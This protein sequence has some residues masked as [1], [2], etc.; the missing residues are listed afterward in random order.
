MW[1]KIMEF[2]KGFA[3]FGLLFMVLLIVLL[4]VLLPENY[5]KYISQVIALVSSLTALVSIIWTQYNKSVEEYN[6]EKQFE[7]DKKH[8]IS[9]EKYQKLFEQKID[10]YQKL[11]SEINK[12]K[13]QSY[14]VGRYIDKIDEYGDIDPQELKEEDVSIETLEKLFKHIGENHFVISNKMMEKY[15]ALYDLYAESRKEFNIMYDFDTI[16]NPKEELK[17]LK[18]S[19]YNNYKKTIDNFFDQIESETK[20]IKKML[21]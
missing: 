6:K 21:E 2:L 7:L 8:Q 4:T 5:D 1:S 13:K 20:Q 9:K 17:K 11:Y 3:I 19:F 14:N 10:V 15:I 18:G 12:F 16:A